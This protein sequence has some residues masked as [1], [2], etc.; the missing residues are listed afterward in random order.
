HQ[1]RERLLRDQ[2]N[3]GVIDG[4]DVVDGSTEVRVPLQFRIWRED[5]LEGC[6]DGASIEGRS[7]VELDT[8]LQLEH[9]RLRVGR[10]PPGLRKL[11]DDLH[12]IIET[13]ESLVQTLVDAE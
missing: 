11:I 9:K 7:V 4:F 12:V 13:D 1:R 3:S 2:A 6:L 8:L 10:R 5:S